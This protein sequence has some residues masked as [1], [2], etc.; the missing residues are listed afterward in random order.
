MKQH[1]HNRLTALFAAAAIGCTAMLGSVPA[2]A[3]FTFPGAAQPIAEGSGDMQAIVPVIV[4]LPGDAVLATDTAAGQGTDFVDSPEAQTLQDALSHQQAEAEA[5]LR[6]L[7]PSLEVEYHY[8]M[9]ANGFSCKL[10]KGLIVQAQSL[11]QIERV[12]PVSTYQAPTPSLHNALP[13]SNAGAFYDATGS[14][15]EGEVICVIDTELDLTH[16]MFAAIDDKANKLSKADIQ[17]IAGKL[18]TKVNASSAYRS[19]KVPFAFDYSSDGT[20]YDMANPDVY[21][22]THVCGIAAGHAVTNSDGETISGLARDAQIVFL[23]VFDYLEEE[24]GYVVTDDVL[25]ASLEDSVKFKPDVINLSLGSP[26]Q[27]LEFS[28]YADAVN[29]I[30]NAG[31][32][33]CAAAG[34]EARRINEDGNYN[35]T[36][37]IDYGT[38]EEPAIFPTALSVASADNSIK[39]AKCLRLGDAGTAIEYENSLERDFAA[40]LGETKLFYEYCG[41]GFPE[42]FEGKDLTG[43]LA[44]IDRGEVSFDVMMKNAQEA[45]AIG[46]IVADKHDTDLFIMDNVVDF[47]AIAISHSSGELLKNAEEQYIIVHE[48][49]YDIVS[50]PPQI[51]SFSSWGV[52]EQLKLKPD[53][54]GIG[55][56]VVSAAYDGEFSD[57]SGT[58]M[59]TPY[60]SG[61]TAALKK[62]LSDA[63]KLP[64][65]GQ[66]AFLRNLLMNSAKLYTLDNGLYV[67]PRQQ[68]AG[69]VDLDAAIRDTVLLTGPDGAAKIELYDKLTDTLSF[70]VNLQNLSDEDVQFTSARLVLT[71]DDS[72]MQDG[73]ATEVVHGSQALTCEAD[74]SALLHAAAGESRTEAITA[75]LDPAQLAEIQTHFPNGFYIDGYLLLEGAANC[76]DIS[77]P[78]LGFYGDWAA[79]PIFDVMQ[80]EFQDGNI[81]YVGSQ[82]YHGDAQIAAEIQAA[83]G[84]IERIPA[85]QLRTTNGY[86]RMSDILNYYY[87]DET[88]GNGFDVPKTDTLYISP[89]GNGI[90][91]LLERRVDLLREAMIGGIYIYD[92]NGKLVGDS[93]EAYTDAY[94]TNYWW[95]DIDLE[96]LA[97]GSYT[98]V[99]TGYICYPAASLQPQELRI[100]FVVDKTNPE[101]TE[102]ITQEDGRTILNLTIEDAS[103]DGVY[104]LGNGTGHAVGSDSKTFTG[105]DLYS[106]LQIANN[107]IVDYSVPEDENTY[108][109][110]DTGMLRYFCN[111]QSSADMQT[112]YEYGF[113]DLLLPETDANG[114]AVIRYDI[115]DLHDYTISV[116]DRAFNT[117]VITEAEMG[118]AGFQ[119]GVWAAKS[120]N[121]LRYYVFDTKDTGVL[122]LMEDEPSKAFQFSIE[123]VGPNFKYDGSKTSD[124]FDVRQLSPISY[125][126]LREEGESEIMTYIGDQNSQ[127]F[128]YYNYSALQELA[129]QYYEATTGETAD[130]AECLLAGNGKVSI[131]IRKYDDEE[132]ETT[133]EGYTVDPLTAKGTDFEQHQVDLTNPSG[134]PDAALGDVDENGSVNAGDAAEVLIAA[135]KIGA[136]MDAG[137]TDTQRIAADVNGDGAINATDAAVILQYAAAIGSGAENVT[138]RD[139]C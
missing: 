56:D 97:E 36:R 51:S 26:D 11:P 43:K 62:Y 28:P 21:H 30:E 91:D 135:A 80:D 116:M 100:P 6:S 105:S 17:S 37:N 18:S 121:S 12:T 38:V 59:A 32:V 93:L 70:H 95:P 112:L 84:Y 68:G 8:D 94:K 76:C 114:N 31:I 132:Y 119:P 103:L 98:G 77:I 23:K 47:P 133:V 78:L 49:D 13:I 71:T 63:G 34:N 9:V 96:T 104:I 102:E 83:L 27:N 75:A 117:T 19:S 85:D 5:A 113:A 81:Q 16:P 101:V 89:D 39:T 22:G 139:F 134:T 33:M 126:A 107:Q 54:T 57:M 108:Q 7:Y 111:D 67:S 82:A 25:L 29:A 92:A 73:Y 41:K 127:T 124:V 64:E 120:E 118:F 50:N 24:G 122:F 1:H 123:G 69:I 60:V 48:D 79:V 88:S 131:F 137:L 128:Q 46:M 44:L 130:V 15:G 61:A 40:V 35:L 110:W 86:D 20:P 99:L 42:D 52:S 74:V 87:T 90:T 45:G 129:M 10:P 53:I 55:G 136:G 125:E 106:A 65:Q 3:G 14:Y 4:T 66:A 72:E 109:P 138:I 2:S 58:S 115:T